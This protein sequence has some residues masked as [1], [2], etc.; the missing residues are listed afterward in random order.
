MSFFG[1]HVQ[2]LIGPTV[3][4]PATPD[5]LEALRSIEVNS[6][7]NGRSG[8]QIG[9][10]AGRSGL[11]ALIDYPLLQNPLLRPFNRVILTA[12][13]DFVPQVL[14]D[15]IITHVQLQ[16]GTEPGSDLLTV[17]G[18]DVSVMMDREERTQEYPAQPEPVIALQLI[19]RYAQY[20][21][22][23]VIIPPPVLDVPIPVERVPVQRGTDYSYL[24]QMAGRVG[25]VFFIQPGPAPFSNIAYWGPPRRIGVP[26]RALSIN[27]GSATNVNSISFQHDALAATVVSGSIQDSRTGAQLPVMTFASL[28]PPLVSRPALPLDYLNA[29]RVLP[30][31]VAGSDFAQAMSRA[32]AVTDQSVDSVQTASGELDAGRYGGLLRARE[33]VGVR[34]A[35]ETHD[36]WYY[37]R[38]V[39]HRIERGSFKQSFE[40]SREGVGALTP[41]V[42]P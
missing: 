12:I 39:S 14:I 15:G 2:L 9:F 3:A 35:G 7:E 19:A 29:R 25:H 23:P 42:I 24:Q 34:G 17:T 27:M 6:S 41:V 22:I 26:Q 4:V 38:R 20:G 40:L 28:R 37:V 5:L 10:S 18:E 11:S 8:F 33:L 1:A 32:Q 36:G 13:F 21:L 16:P 30:Q 31:D